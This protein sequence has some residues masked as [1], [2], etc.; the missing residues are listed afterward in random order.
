LTLKATSEVQISVDSL[1]SSSLRPTSLIVAHRLSTIVNSNVI[2][3]TDHGRTAQCGTHSSLMPHQQGLYYHMQVLQQVTV[4][5]DSERRV[6]L[7]SP[8]V[9]QPHASVEAKPLTNVSI[10]ATQS[11]AAVP[12]SRVWALQKTEMNAIT[13][14]LVLSLARPTEGPTL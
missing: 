13:A 7:E 1:L 14:A 12:E 4:Q 11:H 6:L 2:C 9:A 10:G 8:T 5:I 3:V